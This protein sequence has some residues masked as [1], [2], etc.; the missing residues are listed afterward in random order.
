MGGPPVLPPQGE[1]GPRV[2]KPA[3]EME[4]KPSFEKVPAEAGE[5]K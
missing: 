3:A 1:L 4:E 5:E 2:E